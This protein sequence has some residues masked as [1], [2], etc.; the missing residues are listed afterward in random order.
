M[1]EKV[2]K[3][4]GRVGGG[5]IAMG[6]ILLISGLAMGVLMIISGAGLLRRRAEITF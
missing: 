3:T 1:N 4:M 5:S 6:I 2:F